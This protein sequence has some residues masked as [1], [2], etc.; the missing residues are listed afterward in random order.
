MAIYSAR[1]TRD[2]FITGLRNAHAVENQALSLI[3][4]QLDR[5]VSY[6]EVADHLRMHRAETEG[7]IARLEEI[8]E[9]LKESH[10]SLK[11]TAMSMMGNLAALGHTFAE[12]EILKN[13]FANFAFEN[14]EVASYRSLLAVADAGAFSFAVPLLQKSLGEEE[15][16][17]A[18]ILQNVP[19]ITLKY[20]AL[21]S[22]DETAGR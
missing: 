21:K 17:A 6:P 11:D 1:L 5:V 15:A 19:T 18:W 9:A 22:A 10:S 2:L 4:R 16:M 3:D 20:L 8:L 7:Q 14:F 12:D 13:S